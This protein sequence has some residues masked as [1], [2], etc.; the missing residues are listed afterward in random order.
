VVR[1]FAIG[2]VFVLLV[3]SGVI[4]SKHR[5]KTI[6]VS[7][8]RILD[9][10]QVDSCLLDAR[11]IPHFINGKVDGY[12]LFQIRSG[13]IFADLGLQSG[14]VVVS[15]NGQSLAEF[16]RIPQLIEDVRTASSVDL[17]VQREDRLVRIHYEVRD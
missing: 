4:Y 15:A 12:K 2:A 14:D 5:V 10:I 6:T 8:K 3:L 17:G 1:K 16:S 9:C 7:R 13:S 11:A